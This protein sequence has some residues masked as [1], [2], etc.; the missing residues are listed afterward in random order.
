MFISHNKLS[1]GRFDQ[2]SERQQLEKLSEGENPFVYK[3]K[4]K[5]SEW[6]S[7]KLS[8]RA[9]VSWEKLRK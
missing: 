7:V 6:K 9:N 1:E 2:T 3:V 8:S 5:R 4:S